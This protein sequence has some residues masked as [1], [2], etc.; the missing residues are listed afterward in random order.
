MNQYA[1]KEF[2][3]LDKELKD[4]LLECYVEARQEMEA[5]VNSIEEDG[6]S[7]EKLDSLFRSLHS[8]KGNCSV[9]FLDR[10]V[11]V[12][13]KLEEIVDG[14]RGH[15]IA[16]HSDLGSLTNLVVDEVYILL[17]QLYESHGADSTLALLL[18]SNLDELYS[19]EDDSQRPAKA[20]AILTLIEN[21][22]VGER[23]QEVAHNELLI[24]VEF[25]SAQEKDITRFKE[26]SSK[27]NRL[28]GYSPERGERIVKLCLLINAELQR[29]EDPVQLSAAAYMHDLGMALVLK[30][31]DDEAEHA[32]AVSNH[33]MVGAQL[34]AKYS[35][36]EQAVS[37][38]RSHEERF[39]GNG[40]PE[41]LL[42]SLI[43][44]GAFIVSMSALFIDFIWGKSG[45]D[46]KKSAMR[47]IQKVNQESGKCF[48]PHM[49]DA[50]NLAVKK[51][52]VAKSR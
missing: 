47:A 28:L 32:A 29:P 16:Y 22:K 14:M 40:F 20:A 48:P 38:V 43:P 5:V 9:C 51:M 39:D 34:L 31:K 45:D 15:Y 23:P 13:H 44:T 36:W 42:G 25:S 12:L 41:G 2:S 52:L 50:F 27:L 3:A 33:P 18:K 46:Y 37:I 7:F 35:G 10:F 19:M 26:L 8:M 1:C 11:D 30:V 6:F 4:D 24:K 17:R 49:I 21:Y